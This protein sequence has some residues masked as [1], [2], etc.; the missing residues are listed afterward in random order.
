MLVRMG[1]RSLVALACVAIPAAVRAEVTLEQVVQLALA[2]NERSKIAELDV[3]VSDAQVSKARAQFFPQ[4]QATGAVGYAPWDKS[5]TTT[6][7]GQLAFNLPVFVPTAWPLYDQ[8]KHSLDAQRAQSIDDKRQLAFDAAKAYFAVLLADRVVQAAQQKLDTAKRNVA[9]TTAQ[10]KAQL[11]SSNDVTRATIDQAASERELA[12]DRGSLEGAYQQLELVANAKITREVA[13]PT[14]LVT[15]AQHPLAPPAALV[16]DAIQQRP[17][18][19]SRKAAALAAHDFAREP[20]LRWFPS[21]AFQATGNTATN[22][23]PSGHDV[24]GSLALTA[25]WTLYDAGVREAD[26]RS[27]DASATI[28]DLTAA[29]LAREIAAQ[30]Q[31]AA[32]QLA[33]A[34][35]AL[36]AAQSAM[37]AARKSAD[38][39]AILYHQGLAKAIE[40][41]DAN[42]Q[43]FLA[44]VNHAEAEF[45]LAN[46]YLSLLQASGKG[47]L[48][49][50]AR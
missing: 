49:T 6:A 35:Q 1:V 41:V 50:E 20:R 48:D 22:G 30:V 42:E 29:A 5:P 14:A 18:L 34:Q 33:A 3:A 21:F 27:R 19:V 23:T 2:H 12:L 9:D 17:D 8:A 15:A 44:E 25:S 16:A 11:V 39:T 36:V 31:S 46:A 28:A 24:D 32:A 37:D 47:P 4:L 13:L 40:L 45:S 7:R 38:E 10:L 26:A 43:R